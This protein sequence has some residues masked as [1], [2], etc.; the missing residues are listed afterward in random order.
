MYSKG[1]REFPF[2]SGKLPPANSPFRSEEFAF[3]ANL[4]S[5]HREFGWKSRE[6][7]YRNFREDPLFFGLPPFYQAKFLLDIF[8]GRHI[9]F[10][11]RSPNDQSRVF[12]PMDEI[13]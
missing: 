8:R 5:S 6:N 9:N 10:S 3:S 7:F 13:P 4:L 1:S 12:H 2:L 11:R